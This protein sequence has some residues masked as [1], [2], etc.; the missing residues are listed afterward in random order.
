MDSLLGILVYNLLKPVGTVLLNGFSAL[1]VHAGRVEHLQ[2]CCFDF[3]TLPLAPHKTV[4][5]RQEAFHEKQL[6]DDIWYHREEY[7][8][9]YFQQLVS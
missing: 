2:A 6:R 7:T 4:E 5:T 8:G 1:S 3:S 9:N